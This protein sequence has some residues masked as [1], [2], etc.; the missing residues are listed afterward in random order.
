[1]EDNNELKGL[2]GWLILVGLGVVLTPVRL[3]IQT[4]PVYADILSDGTW[5]ALT[6]SG[7]AYYHPLWQPLLLGEMIVNAG[8]FAVSLYLIYLF[9]SRH[10]LFPRFFIGL[11]LASVIVIPLDA[12]LVTFVLPHEPMFDPETTR[13]FARVLVFGFIWVPYMLVSRRVRATF[14]E[15]RPEALP[16][17]DP[18]A[19]RTV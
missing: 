10:Y 16:D 14:V 13:E 19:R 6:G 9:F 5:E 12:W 18:V 7:S 17:P 11:V 3:A 4:V 2:G 8:I 15:K 1:M